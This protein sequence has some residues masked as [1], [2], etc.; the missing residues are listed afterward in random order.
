[1]KNNPEKICLQ[2]TDIAVLPEIIANER[3]KFSL[4]EVVNKD[5]RDLVSYVD[6]N[7]EKIIVEG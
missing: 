3:K 5:K 4:T 2:A 1:L 6:V 7:A